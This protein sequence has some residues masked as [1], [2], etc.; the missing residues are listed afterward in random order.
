MGIGV[1]KEELEE[2]KGE[3]EEGKGMRRWRRKEEA[4]ARKE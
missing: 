4:R 3:G 1:R 2:Y